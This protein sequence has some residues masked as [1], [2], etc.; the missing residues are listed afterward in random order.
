MDFFTIT[1]EELHALEGLPYI[2]QL[3]YFRGIR[4]YMD[5]KTGIT[6]V[7]RRI[8][9]QS[10]GEALYIEPHS[11]IQESGSP[12]YDQVRRAIK[13]LVKTG[14]I[15]VQP[16]QKQLIFKCVLALRD[17]SAQNKPASKSP[18]EA[19]SKAPEENLGIT[20]NSKL[21][22]S[23]ATTSKTAQPATPHKDNNY[24][25][26]LLQK[27]EAFWGSYPQK[28]G[29]QKA[30]QVFQELN[31]DEPLMQKILRALKAQVAT[32]NEKKTL[33]I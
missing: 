9:Y 18:Y 1:A 27:F 4:P 28:Q 26:F 11:G 12:N 13:H 19:T 10:L 33:G 2:Q 21:Y 22:H 25:F 6:G 7:K 29:K 23:K 5:R 8:S 20:P 15:E 16:A 30:W 17:K 31:P 14:L 24:L 32:V 3:L